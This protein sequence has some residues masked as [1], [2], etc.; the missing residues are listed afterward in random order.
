MKINSKRLKVSLLI[1]A[2]V[3]SATLVGCGDSKQDTP[4]LAR[5]DGVWQ[6]QGNPEVWQFN[7]NELAKYSINTYGCIRFSNEKYTDL[8]GLEKHLAL[9]SSSLSLNNDATNTWRFSKL[10]ALPEACNAQNQLDADSPIDN[11]EF[12]WHHFND[13]YAF[14]ELRDIDWQAIYTQYRPAIT[15]QTTPAQLEQILADIISRFD[16]SHV[17]LTT[18]ADDYS[19]TGDLKGLPL[20]ALR[21]LVLNGETDIDER[22]ET[23]YEQMVTAR[24]SLIT[25]YINDPELTTQGETGAVSWGL[26]GDNIGYLK[27]SKEHQMLK[28]LPESGTILELLNNAEQDYADTDE[29]MQA[30]MNALQDTEVLIIDLRLNEGGYDKVS[31]K[32]ASY[33]NDQEKVFGRKQLTSLDGTITDVD[34]TV[35]SVA[36]PYT[37]PIYVISGQSNVSAGEVLTM[38]LTSLD[39]VTLIG[40][41]SNGSVSDSLDFTLPNGW[42]ASLSNQ[43]YTDASG[44]VIE[45]SGVTPDE[46]VPV[47]AI[48]D[49]E[50]ESDNAIDAVLQKLNQPLPFAITEPQLDALIEKTRQELTIPGLSIAVVHDGE[51]VFENGYGEKALGTGVAVTENTPFNVGSISKAVLGTAIMQKL[52][53]Q[54]INLDTPVNDLDLP[55]TVGHPDATEAITLR[56]LVTHT[57]GIARAGLYFADFLT[58]Q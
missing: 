57:S 16:D 15:A 2:I 50:Y 12:F 8:D 58:K 41:P 38:A 3:S 56:H 31:Q 18:T 23:V 35:G 24:G 1:S 49:F 26:M 53:Q 46:L 40:Q 43:V 52:E 28:P 29:V 27:I 32:I 42:Q 14:F 45:G 55:F 20:E 34:L 39:H 22:I 9:N 13:N 7:N 25:R 19:G 11:F 48:E 51:I 21:Y 17:S 33:F 10:S 47:Y 6:Q 37:K 30:A 36:A 5:Y 4:P 54:Q 44:H